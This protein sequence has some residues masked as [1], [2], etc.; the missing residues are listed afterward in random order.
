MLKKE[1][2]GEMIKSGNPAG[3][4][5]LGI[6]FRLLTCGI[7]AS[8]QWAIVD[9]PGLGDSDCGK[10]SHFSSQSGNLVT[11]TNGILNTN[12]RFPARPEL[13]KRR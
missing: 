4:W 3:D 6:R 11:F 13:F 1:G 7:T 2:G 10:V 9:L 12:Y 8:R 5:R